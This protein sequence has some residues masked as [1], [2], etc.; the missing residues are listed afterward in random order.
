VR[1]STASSMPALQQA[2]QRLQQ[3]LEAA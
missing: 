3:M 2:V 1:F